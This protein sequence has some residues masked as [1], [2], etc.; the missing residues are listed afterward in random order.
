[1][2]DSS[3]LLPDPLLSNP[4]TRDEKLEQFRLLLQELLRRKEET[5]Y[6]A[7]EPLPHQARFHSSKVKERAFIGSNRC[8]KTEANAAECVRCAEGKNPHWTELPTPNIG[9]V[10]SLTN[11]VQREILQPKFKKLLPKGCKIRYRP[12]DV[13]DQ[14]IFPNGSIIGFKS[15][16][17]GRESMQGVALHWVSIDEECPEDIFEELRARIV[18]YSGRLWITFTPLNGMTWSHERYVDPDTKIDDCE[19]FTATM[20]DNAVSRGGYIPDAEIQKLEDS[21][22]DPVLKLV[23]I[24][25]KYAEQIGRIYKTFD[26]KV[27]G[28]KK[29]QLPPG[30][31]G[32]DGLPNSNFDYYVSL[33][34]GRN[35]SAGFYMV[36]YHGNV[37][38]FTGFF[39]TDGTIGRRAITI[40]NMCNK[41]GIQPRFIVDPSTQFYR[42]LEEHGIYCELGDN[43]VDTGIANAMEYM[44]PKGKNAR[45]GVPYGNPRYYVVLDDEG[46]ERHL[47]EMNR[48]S[49]D[50]PA[51]TGPTAGE[52][53]NKPRK[54]DDHTMDEMRYVLKCK[55]EPP[56]PPPGTEDTRPAITRI[57]EGIK[58]KIRDRKSRRE[59]STDEGGFDDGLDEY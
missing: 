39:D 7:Y 9:W 38:R 28:I 16:E 58:K 59:G 3:T 25:G 22:K 56:K 17:Q 12:N 55:P 57:T 34:T 33:D 46:N 4:P 8:G 51:R 36:D 40:L 14:V 41:L 23:R 52:L 13:W 50:V 21:I 44:T 32:E 1:M 6:E 53:K 27:N 20:W 42:E 15:C 48:Y 18:D 31:F 54:K 19:V 24:Y 26:R 29:S 37:I 35:F 11:E 5:P 43:D 47:Y 2:T 10:I 45:T 30:Y 49:W